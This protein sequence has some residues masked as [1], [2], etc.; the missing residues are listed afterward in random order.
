MRIINASPFLERE[1]ERTIV[2]HAGQIGKYAIL[3]HRWG[4]EVNYTEMSELTKLRKSV[5]TKS[6][7]AKVTR[8][9]STVASGLKTTTSSGYGSIHCC[10]DKRSSSELSEAI[11]SM[12]QWYKN[13]KICYPCLHDHGWTLQEPLAPRNLEFFHKDYGF[14]A[15]QAVFASLKSWAAD[16][17]TTRIEDRAYLVL[18]LLDMN[19]PMLYGE[20]KGAL[21]CLQPEIICKSNDRNIFAMEQYEGPV[22]SW[23][24]S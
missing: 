17:K 4:R 21:H 24:L 6:G 18:S 14:T 11:Y 15:L 16:R 22:I 8:R 12:Y 23:R 13:V 10:I 1:R 3:S 19:M 5:R 9:F 20:G 2:F 7:G